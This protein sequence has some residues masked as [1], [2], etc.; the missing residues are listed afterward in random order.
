M[1]NIKSYLLIL[2]IFI[3]ISA[4]AQ[5]IQKPSGSNDIL[6]DIHFPTAS[7]GYVVGS[8]GTI[9]KSD[10]L[11]ETWNTI[12][13]NQSYSFESVYF[14]NEDIGF[15]VGQN[16]MLKTSDGGNSW[17][18]IN[19]PIQAQAI[20]TDIKFIDNLVGFC[21][22][23]GKIL[24]TID[25]GETWVVKNSI[26]RA[27][28]KIF[29]HDLT[30][31]YV[32]S[33]PS[34]LLKTDDAGE[35]W[36]MIDM[37]PT[38]VLS[39][40]HEIIGDLFFTSDNTG[41]FAGYYYSILAKTLDGGNTWFCA[42]SNCHNTSSIGYKSLFFTSDNIGYA[43]GDGVLKTIDGGNNWIEQISG[44]VSNLSSV[45]FTD[46]NIGYAVGFQGVILKTINGG[47]LGLD[48]AIKNNIEIKIFP[49]PTK[50]TLNIEID[51]IDKRP[52]LLQL[53]SILG[54]KLLDI[55]IVSFS[56]SIDLTKYAEGIY[57]YKLVNSDSEIIK[58]GKIIKN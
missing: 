6:T 4:N 48:T 10:D 45:Y 7:V 13:L 28:G 22:A 23:D 35:T 3:F 11:G 5:W 26:N 2:N 1:K 25:G 19:L 34:K 50:S 17:N 40:T 42:N 20:Y 9:L 49:I 52:L 30:N 12:Y 29:F 15:V 53:Y 14:I 55:K 37:N 54:E 38:G 39:P 43:V 36:S 27:V 32:L 51:S 16:I 41:H 33:S 44:D 21:S 8:G 57:T 18:I 56:E 58:I 47:T 24:K 31:G 46:N